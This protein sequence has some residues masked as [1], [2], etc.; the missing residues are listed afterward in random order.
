VP[1]TFA[2]NSLDDNV[3]EMHTLRW[4]VAHAENG[5]TILNTAPTRYAIS[6]HCSKATAA[7]GKPS[8]ASPPRQR[9]PPEHWFHQ[10][11]RRLH[12]RAGSVEP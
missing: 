9:W 2:V 5:D 6:E 12:D 11:K 10:R 7:N 1:S 8:G 3:A 4:A